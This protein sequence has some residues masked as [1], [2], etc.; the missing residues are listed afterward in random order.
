MRI[1]RREKNPNRLSSVLPA[2]ENPQFAIRNRN[3]FTLVELGVVIVVLGI[4]LTLV[5]PSLNEI[6]GSNLKKS[7]RHLTGTIRFL[8]DEAEAKKKIFRLRFDVS[9]G[10]YWAEAPVLI[11]DDTVEF[12]KIDSVISTEGSLSGQTVMRS[13]HVGSHPDDPFI[14]FTPDGW[15]EKSFI[16]LQDGDGKDYTLLVKPLTGDTELLEGRVEEK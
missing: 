9:N 13:I 5:I 10:H 4:M 12:K 6:T 11:D 16:Y 3:G 7:A 2:I 14:L 15:V 8:R 1:E